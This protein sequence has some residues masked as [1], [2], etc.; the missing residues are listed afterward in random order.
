[1]TREAAWMSFD[2]QETGSL[3]PGKWAGMVILDRN[4]LTTPSDRL[5]D[6]VVE[7]LLLKGKRW[8][9]TGSLPGILLRGI[10]GGW[11]RVDRSGSRLT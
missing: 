6:I 8:A 7:E 4:P 11:G 3:E 9:G 1:M 2:E 10:L 5:K